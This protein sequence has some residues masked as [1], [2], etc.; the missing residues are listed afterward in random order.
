[1]RK[2]GGEFISLIHP[3]AIVNPTAKIGDGC[4]VLQYASIGAGVVIEDYVLVQ[5][6]AVVGHDSIIGNHS[7]L[8]CNSVCVGGVVLKDEVTIHTSAVISHKVVVGNGAVVGGTSFVIRKVRENTTV[9]GNPAKRL[10]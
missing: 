3:T 4:I 8:D 10:I 6:S 1:M 9:F 2:K 5:I 7:R